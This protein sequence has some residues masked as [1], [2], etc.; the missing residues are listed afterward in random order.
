M[1]VRAQGE[2][3]N[4]RFIVGRGK[5]KGKSHPA[6]LAAGVACMACSYQGLYLAW[7]GWLAAVKECIWQIMRPTMLEA[8]PCTHQKKSHLAVAWVCHLL[9]LSIPL[10]DVADA[11]PRLVH[12][13]RHARQ[14]RRWWRWP[15]RSRGTRRCCSWKGWWRRWGK[16][17]ARYTHT[18]S[19]PQCFCQQKNTE[20]VRRR[21]GQMV[22]ARHAT[23]FAAK[24]APPLPGRQLSP[25]CTQARGSFHHS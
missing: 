10:D 24:E 2:V 3:R 18:C 14:R 1:H 19:A 17:V 4:R 20:G 23:E 13:H 21:V 22:R 7:L 25:L 8:D 15:A 6:A 12:H 16:S 9:S 11:F 5:R